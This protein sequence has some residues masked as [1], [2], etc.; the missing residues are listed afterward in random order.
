MAL[1]DLIAIIAEQEAK[2]NAGG[3]GGGGVVTPGDGVGHFW[4]RDTVYAA[5]NEIQTPSGSESYLIFSDADFAAMSVNHIQDQGRPTEMAIRYKIGGNPSDANVCYNRLR[6]DLNNDNW[7]PDSG[8]TED[9]KNAFC[10]L[11]A[12]ALCLEWCKNEWSSAQK[13]TILDRIRVLFLNGA[14]TTWSPKTHT[15]RLTGHPATFWQ[16]WPMLAIAAYGVNS[17]LFD[18]LLDALYDDDAIDANNFYAQSGRSIHGSYT[19]PKMSGYI[20]LNLAFKLLVPEGKSVFTN[21]IENI[22]YSNVLYAHRH[23]KMVMVDEVNLNHWGSKTSRPSSITGFSFPMY[24]YPTTMIAHCLAYRDPYIY[25]LYQT[26]SNSQNIEYD[27][28]VMRSLLQAGNSAWN[29]QSAANDVSLSDLPNWIWNDFPV[30]FTTYKS[31]HTFDQ[32]DNKNWYGF[33]LNGTETLMSNHTPHQS[34]NL[35]LFGPGG[36]MTV[37]NGGWGSN[38]PYSG[39]A[40]NVDKGWFG[41]SGIG[42]RDDRDDWDLGA[43]TNRERQYGPRIPL[44]KIK[45]NGSWEPEYYENEVLN[46]RFGFFVCENYGRFAEANKNPKVLYNCLDQTKGFRGD[47]RY[48]HNRFNRVTRSVFNFPLLQTYAGL[49]ITI[50]KLDITGMMDN[51]YKPLVQWTSAREFGVNNDNTQWYADS[52]YGRARTSAV[53]YSDVPFSID[54]FTTWPAGMAPTV[55]SFYVPEG[56]SGDRIVIEP[57]S[58]NSYQVI[59]NVMRTGFSNLAL[60]NPG[61]V[62]VCITNNVIVVECMGRIAVTPYGTRAYRCNQISDLT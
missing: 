42:R 48:F 35:E 31:D 19:P 30:S 33:R 43:D 52:D 56:G 49:C 61:D 57:N 11:W 12:A 62:K 16:L 36:H 60:L 9:T 26:L 40:V 44:D 2:K 34:G 21:M 17:S 7:A 32:N 6:D 54:K 8:Y 37:G 20:A 53:V 58:L 14:N 13:N 24:G 41:M 46:P 22:A 38:K 15:D 47:G 27:K 28:F 10:L 3:G 25:K 18:D 23:N 45:S 50:D 5:R 29:F 4:Y 51:P 59:I 55:T 39:H 1:N